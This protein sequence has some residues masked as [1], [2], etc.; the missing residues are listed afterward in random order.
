MVTTLLFFTARLGPY[1]PYVKSVYGNIHCQVET[2]QK[3]TNLWSIQNA[4]TQFGILRICKLIAKSKHH[5]MEYFFF[6]LWNCCES[7]QKTTAS[8]LL[9]QTVM[10]TNFS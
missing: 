1:D 8:C 5:N 4:P 7:V 6:P 2:E 10:E 9:I 3:V